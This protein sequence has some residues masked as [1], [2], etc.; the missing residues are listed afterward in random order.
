[1]S[2]GKQNENNVC[3]TELRYFWLQISTVGLLL[4]KIKTTRVS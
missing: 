3:A 2:N 4:V 1:M